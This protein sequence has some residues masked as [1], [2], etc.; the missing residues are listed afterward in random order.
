MTAAPPVPPAV[1]GCG[2][3]PHT[4]GCCPRHLHP[5]Q[6]P[7]ALALAAAAAACLACCV[8]P[9]FPCLP[10]WLGL[11][12]GCSLACPQRS[13]RLRSQCGLHD[14]VHM[15]A[16]AHYMMVA[17]ET[18]RKSM[19]QLA[20][21]AQAGCCIQH[22]WCKLQST[23]PMFLNFAA[24]NSTHTCWQLGLRFLCLAPCAP[25]CLLLP[26]SLP[27]VTQKLS[28]LVTPAAKKML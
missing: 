16:A 20:T 17:P 4:P 26:S 1:G 7:M 22:S 13:D 27:S 10:L 19:G 11:G 5:A 21:P 9:F 28:L 23:P 18:T 14:C 25:C 8:T 12:G 2:C 15:S 3:R 24:P 6:T